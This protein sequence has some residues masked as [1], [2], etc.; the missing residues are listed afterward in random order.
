MVDTRKHIF[1]GVLEKS[2]IKTASRRRYKEIRD[3]YSGILSMGI[4]RD[5]QSFGRRIG[6]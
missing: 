6:V 2:G 1:Y 5:W 3:G 4:R